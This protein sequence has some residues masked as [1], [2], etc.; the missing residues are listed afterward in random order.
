MPLNQYISTPFGASIALWKL[1]EDKPALTARLTANEQRLI[2]AQNLSP[3]RF[4]ER[5]ATRLL[6]NSMEETRDAEIGYTDNGKPYMP[7]RSG[8]ISISHTAQWVAVA[9]HP[10][11]PI[12][13]DLEQ[14]GTKVEKVAER[15]FNGQELNA[16]SS[17]PSTHTEWLHL[18]WSGKEALFKAI[19]E[20]GIDFRA[21][22]HLSAPPSLHHEGIFTAQ[23]KRTPAAK[24]YSLWYR[25]F[26][27]FV[28]VCAAPL[29]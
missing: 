2:E 21:H 15:V 6:L 25:I 11:L 22:L 10:F 8:H 14:I 27:Q 28:M 26:D 18:C 12:G 29:Q 4:C 1:S 20:A 19:P 5:A 13:I 7:H 17:S 23:E 24:E 9:Y 16:H 3:K